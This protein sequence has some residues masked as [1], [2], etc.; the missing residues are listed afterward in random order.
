MSDNEVLLA[1]FAAIQVLTVIIGK[2]VDYFLDK[3]KMDPLEAK[4]DK[5]LELEKA[6]QQSINEMMRVKVED[7]RMLA[8]L[9]TMHKVIDEDGRPAW[10]FPKKMLDM[11][12]KHL[13]MLREIS[14]AQKDAAHEMNAIFRMF[15]SLKE[16]KS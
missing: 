8:D 3:G 16:G 14:V 4:I 13:E 11:S 9:Y 10:F 12:E 6:R 1:A 2:V 7:S 5:L 15:V